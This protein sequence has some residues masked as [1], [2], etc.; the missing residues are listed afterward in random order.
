MLY[1]YL[2]ALV[3]LLCIV[4]CNALQAPNRI[5]WVRRKA[6]FSSAENSAE[7]MVETID[8]LLP[9]LKECMGSNMTSF[10][11]LDTVVQ[12]NAEGVRIRTN[13]GEELFVKTVYAQ[14]YSHKAWPDL[15]RTLL[16]GRTEVRF[17]NETLPKM[18]AKGLK[19]MAPVCYRATCN[20][21]GLISDSDRAVDVSN[22]DPEETLEG[23]GAF[24]AL[25]TVDPENYFQDSP[26]T[27]DQASQCL[28]A[29]AKIHAAAWEDHDIL[30]SA[31]DRLSRGSYHLQMRAPKELPGMVQAWDS[32]MNAF[33]DYAPELFAKPSVQQ[34]GQRI[35]NVAQK[36]SSELSP[37]PNDP[38]ATLVHGDYKA[39]N[40]FLPKTA[41]DEAVMID[42]AST[43]VGLGMSDVAMH[44][45]HALRPCEIDEETL[46]N[47]YLDALSEARLLCNK[48]AKPYPTDVAMRHFRL[49]VIDYFRFFLGRFWKSATLESMEKKKNSKN[50]N[51][52]NRDPDAAMAFVAT[53][54]RFLTEYENNK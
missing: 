24:L 22:D 41:S 35:F 1:A 54:D 49:A 45:Y 10:E 48:D 31:A 8:D 23:R 18:E 7:N 40:V 30:T 5:G 15:R 17:Y 39:M 27:P 28:A 2:A 37:G 50:T 21:D 12:A 47:G 26:L 43:G 25:Q 34:L 33:K 20:L 9:R 53:V 52:I 4:T 38:Y 16:Y 51:L 32:F 44:I 13:T 46:L 14:N 3:G 19:G 36:V 6:V 29:V 42:F 11:I